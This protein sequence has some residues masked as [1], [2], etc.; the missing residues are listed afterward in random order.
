MTTVYIEFVLIAGRKFNDD[1]ITKTAVTI[2]RACANY[3][4][5]CNFLQ[6][7]CRLY[8]GFHTVSILNQVYN[9]SEQHGI[10]IVIGGQEKIGK[11]TLAC[12]APNSLLV[13]LEQG[14]AAM[15][16][17]KTPQ[18]SSWT[19]VEQLCEELIAAAKSG[20]LARG[21]TIVWDSGTALERF[22]H[23][24]ILELDTTFKKKNAT[25]LT[26]ESA[27]GGYGK[28]YNLANDLFARWSRYQDDLAKYAGI[29][30]V[31]TCHVFAVKMLDPAF[32]E[33]D[34]WD[35]LLHSP[36]NNKTYGKREF[37][38]QWADMV[39]FLHEPMFVLKAGEGEKM[40]RAV[41]ANQGRVLAVERT[42][43]WVA[44]NR[45]GIQGVIPIAPLN[46]WNY[47]AQAIWDKSGIDVFNR[48]VVA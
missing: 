27:H 25:S 6:W 37:I 32:G 19:E 34:Q 7:S 26:M 33:F 5:Y 8:S 14:G 30:I 23:Q 42:P 9:Q 2:R 44:G 3:S 28:A 17:P 12:G 10:R 22:I 43:Q 21:S 47:L 29:N 48:A 35:L 4:F 38:T 13:Q 11:T 1:R 24:H 36:K 15:R 18:L 16:V 46:G 45:F 39:G 20:S 40:N 41:S 31:V